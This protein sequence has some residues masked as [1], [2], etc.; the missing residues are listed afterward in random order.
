M[1]TLLKRVLF[2]VL[3]LFGEANVENIGFVKINPA[4]SNVARSML[5]V[6]GQTNGTAWNYTQVQM[7]ASASGEGSNQLEQHDVHWTVLAL[8]L[9]SLDSI[10][11]HRVQPYVEEREN[12]L[13]GLSAAMLIC[14]A[15]L[16]LGACRF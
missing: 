9:L 15:V 12:N 2:V 4:A 10:L 5:R 11:L 13:E 1:W 16:R 8:I 3:Y 6:I 14:I 7:E